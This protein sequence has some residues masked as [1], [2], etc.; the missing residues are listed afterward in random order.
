MKKHLIYILTLIICV[1][2]DPVNEADRYE[3]VGEVDI[4]GNNRVVLLEEFTGQDCVNCP[5]AHKEI[6]K[7]EE[8]YGDRFVCV[9]IHA[10]DFALDEGTKRYPTFKTAEGDIY[11]EQ[12]GVTDLPCGVVNKTGGV[13]NYNNWASSI[14]TTL[15]QPTPLSIKL[16]AEVEDGNISISSTLNCSEALNGKLQLWVVE[17]GIVSLQKY[18]DGKSTTTIGD[19]VHN[20]IYRAS[21]NGVGGESISLATDT[22]QSFSHTIG[23]RDHWEASNLR[24]VGFVYNNTGVVQVA[25]C[26]VAV[27]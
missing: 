26:E 20:N 5:S 18:N 10:T 7:M 11:A 17:D 14:Y 19:Y 2:C 6:E 25:Q 23:M 16:Q 22:P 12:Y 8:S 1:A 4:T 13:Q 21:V 27:L 15:Q 24:I 3:Y 9:S